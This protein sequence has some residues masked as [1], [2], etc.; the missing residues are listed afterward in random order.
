MTLSP[1]I[2]ARPPKFF[3]LL[4]YEDPAA[5]VDWLCA[6]FGLSRHFVAKD[7]R[8]RVTHAQLRLGEDL[9]MLGPDNPVDR[10]GMHSPRVLNGLN[11]GVCVALGDVDAHCAR[12]RAAGAEILTAPH[13][14]DHGARE[15]VARDL[16]GHVWTFGS[17]WGEP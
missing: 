10:Y 14:T 12:A 17:Y 15:Y 8:G 2:P 3:P 9:L 7:E 5:A 13:D 1:D 6:A 11:Q 4:R 16:E